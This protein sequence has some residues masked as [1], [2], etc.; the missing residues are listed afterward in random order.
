MFSALTLA[1]ELQTQARVQ[2]SQPSL[3]DLEGVG[4]MLEGMEATVNSTLFPIESYPE[5]RATN[6]LLGG[7]ILLYL[8]LYCI[9]TSKY[10]MA[11]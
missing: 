3:L 5:N 7:A 9:L 4:S 2:G 1:V 8:K 11:A 10:P 6:G